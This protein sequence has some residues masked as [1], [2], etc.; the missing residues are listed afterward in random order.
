[1]RHLELA[2]GLS[3]AEG[4]AVLAA[5]VLAAFLG[6]ALL[7][8][9]R[10]RAGPRLATGAL[11]ALAA[12]ALA[13]VM[14][15]PAA[16][17]TSQKQTRPRVA[18]LVDRSASMREADLP[19]GVERYRLAADLLREGSPL[20]GTLERR[21]RPVYLAFDSQVRSVSPA[22][23]DG[24]P[25]GSA[26]DLVGGLTAA[27]D[28]PGAGPLAGIVMI[29]DGRATRGPPLGLRLAAIAGR[30][31]PIWVLG[32]GEEGAPARPRLAV[33][34]FEPPETA[35]I[36]QVIAL[37]ASVRA[38][39]MP[40]RKVAVRL[41]IDGKETA[42]RELT[43]ASE[44]AR[45]PVRFDY[46]AKAQGVHRFEIIAEAPGP[47]PRPAPT[48][49]SSRYLIVSG[50]P[51]RAFYAEARLGWG[52]R[53]LAG[54]LASAPGSE[55]EL[56]TGFVR[57]EKQKLELT[58]RLARLDTVVLGDVP[59]SRLGRKNLAA[60]ARAVRED[61][62][63]LLF[64]VGP[65]RAASY[66]GTPLE[67]LLPVKLKYGKVAAG[68][69]R[70]ELAA[71]GRRPEPLRLDRSGE[72]DHRLWKSL[73]ATRAGW[74]PGALRPGARVWL[75]AGTDPLLAAWPAGAGR[76][77]VLAWPDHWR[78]SRSGPAGAEG[79]RRLFARTA[80]WLAGRDE[81]GSGKLAL[82]MT[83]YRLTSGEQV[84][85][86]ARLLQ[87]PPEGSRVTLRAEI[88]PPG[89]GRKL[90][91]LRLATAAPG[92]YRAT[93]RAGAPGEYRVRVT[94]TSPQGQWARAELLFTVEGSNFEMENPAPDFAALRGLAVAS[95]GAFLG[96]AEAERLPG[97]LARALPGPRRR[98][99]RIRRSLWDHP[100]L[101]ALALLASCLA[102]LMLRD[103]PDKE[104]PT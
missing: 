61:G 14:L 59:A 57:G 24:P 83:R 52:Y 93:V 56:W 71:A 23:L 65:E 91:E 95:G 8:A 33:V 36:G 22:D 26:T 44:D 12:A 10:R 72:V 2:G 54:A 94:A 100:A 28:S 49:R 38:L 5:A 75:R 96:P 66:A 103:G 58:G 78:W 90:R 79:H 4:L 21:A 27:L 67:P 39:N 70:V 51:L 88:G 77:A 86:L 53:A 82:S 85:L 18:V 37:D 40:G 97:M 45:L 47:G 73:P 9:R 74:K 62:L 87:S 31:V 35:V 104:K 16:V 89:K 41:L 76:V 81:S 30:K 15:R 17:T 99:R 13:T 101:L 20:R 92:R 43:V 32:A 50:R 84:S 80:A 25:A 7:A 98:T 6:G 48:A 19:T 63:G 42:R 60:L 34:D 102:W 64:A 3:L 46:P 29:T 68:S 55:L 69:R 11:Y 1:M